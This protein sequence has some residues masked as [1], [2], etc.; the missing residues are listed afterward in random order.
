M[1]IKGPSWPWSSATGPVNWYTWGSAD[2]PCFELHEAVMTP[3]GSDLL[4]PV[5]K[6]FIV[7][8]CITTRALVASVP[9]F[10]REAVMTLTV[11]GTDLMFC[12]DV[13]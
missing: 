5:E 7:V 4:G 3:E 2:A 1:W 11:G 6:G 10:A 9:S 12:A 8:S 13:Y